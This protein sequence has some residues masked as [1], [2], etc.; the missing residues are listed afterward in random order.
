MRICRTE[1]HQIWQVSGLSLNVIVSLVTET[2]M[3]LF[4][5]FTTAKI[6]STHPPIKI[7]LSNSD[8]NGTRT[9]SV[10]MSIFWNIQQGAT[11]MLDWMLNWH[12]NAFILW[13]KIIC[14]KIILTIWT[15]VDINLPKA[16]LTHPLWEVLDWRLKWDLFYNHSG[17]G[18]HPWELFWSVLQ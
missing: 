16:R 5:F 14:Y 2:Q 11:K 1:L 7:K 15:L 10:E 8:L 4:F 12:Y 3:G 9:V 17:T 6:C 18:W 13:E